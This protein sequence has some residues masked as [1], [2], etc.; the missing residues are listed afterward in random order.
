MVLCY[1]E[2]KIETAWVMM[3]NLYAF[4]GGSGWRGWCLGEACECT[5]EGGKIYGP[6]LVWKKDVP[7]D[8]WETR[9]INWL[10]EAQGRAVIV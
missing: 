9:A 6:C 2:S 3:M 10:R 4:A 1:D 8:T 5:C 7:A